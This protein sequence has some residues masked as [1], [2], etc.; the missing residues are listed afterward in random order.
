[1]GS[2]RA[3]DPIPTESAPP[4]P[5]SDATPGDSVPP[6]NSSS[7]VFPGHSELNQPA[8]PSEPSFSLHSTPAPSEAPTAGIPSGAPAANTSNFIFPGGSPDELPDHLLVVYNSTDSS[9][10]DLALYY[11]RRRNIPAERI[12]GI[13]CPQEEE[14]SRAQYE[15]TIREPI[16][17]YIY[18]KGWMTRRSVPARLN[19]AMRD[20]LIAT[21]NEIW[22]MVLMR[23]VPLKIAQDSTLSS[24]LEQ[25]E[26]LQT[27][28]AAVDS[29]LALL[30]VFGLPY[31]G[32]VPNIFY[33]STNNGVVRAGPELATKLIL[34]TRL[35]GPRFADVHRM[36]DDTLYAEQHRLAGLAV[37]DTRGLDDVR[38]AYTVGD[39]WL[40]HAQGMLH[41]EGW[42]V[43]FD[44]SSEVI[45]PSDPLN[46]V[47]LYL[48][49]YRAD[50]FGPWVT[51]PDRFERGAIA[52]HLHSFSATTIH[53]TTAGWVG[54]LIAH[55][56]AAT[57]GCVYEP[58]LDL[59]P[60][61]DIFTRRLLDGDT[62]AEAAYASQRG[63][64]WMVTVVGDPLYRPFRQPL[65][66]ALG[67][68]GSPTSDHYDWLLLQQVQHELANGDL[69]NTTSALEQALDVPG[70]AAQE[71]LG[72]LLQKVPYDPDAFIA[73]AG[74]YRNASSLEVEP[75][76]RIR[77][78][79]K[80]A[81]LY[82]SSG[83]TERAQAELNILRD[84][85]PNDAARFGVAGV[86]S[87]SGPGS[88][89]T[90]IPN[91]A[92]PTLQP[93]RSAVDAAT[94]PR[95]PKPPG[96]P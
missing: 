45:P 35:D 37:L 84:L 78:G 71:G 90:G 21:H 26:A 29:E 49:W 93:S 57:M 12:L 43:K 74:A 68:A 76:D 39:S 61:L 41:Q 13:A 23:G 88:N 92:D 51:P 27:N 91:L 38:N 75:I 69:A 1:M 96:A 16:I 60:H 31:G 86:V 20:L 8:P 3:A 89:P 14:I 11:A 83:Q 24:S 2:L 54:P 58:Y 79:L 72:D 59:T 62:F 7:A 53:S 55:G 22:A 25:G 47:A 33:D 17:S 18:K 6:T 36:I 19:G 70:A 34:V 28:A 50:A 73:A 85:Y 80:L 5:A 67:T 95:P 4:S 65:D 56:A 64:S 10:K 42:M 46:H 66:T 30:P 82:E 44:T 77:V 32:F 52:Y 94:I 15:A 48:G 9:S 40:R 87:S 81:Q 63:L